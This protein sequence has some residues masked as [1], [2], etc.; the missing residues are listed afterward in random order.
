MH[1]DTQRSAACQDQPTTLLATQQVVKGQKEA[2]AVT[3][4]QAV[5]SLA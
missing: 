2:A 1:R 3:L 5:G 4:E